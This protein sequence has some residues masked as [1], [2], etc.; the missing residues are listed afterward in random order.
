MTLSPV[1]SR[2]LT[3]R[4][5]DFP[6]F[7]VPSL[8]TYVCITVAISYLPRSQSYTS[9]SCLYIATP[10]II[11][12]IVAIAIAF[13]FPDL[14]SKPTAC[15]NL[16]FRG[17]YLRKVHTA[18][19]SPSDHS[20]ILTAATDPILNRSTNPA[21]FLYSRPQARNDV[22]LSKYK[23]YVFVYSFLSIFVTLNDFEST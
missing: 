16:Y 18:A 6:I 14:I 17:I 8:Y 21:W 13:S 12:I 22:I 20:R 9:T 3:P 11:A 7:L 2:T 15:I 23:H 10:F 1:F 5:P 19:R 4:F